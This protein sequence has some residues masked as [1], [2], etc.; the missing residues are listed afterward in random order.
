MKKT[1]TK[2]KS[3]PAIEWVKG[4]RPG[5]WVGGRF[6]NP[7]PRGRVFQ[8]NANNQKKQKMYE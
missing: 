4:N 1:N 5:E 8:T 7:R 2:A 6:F 3:A